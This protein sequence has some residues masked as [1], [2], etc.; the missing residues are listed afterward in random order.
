MAR[1]RAGYLAPSAVIFRTAMREGIFGHSRVW[2]VVGIA[3]LARRGL[4]KL[5]GAAPRTLAVERIRPGEMLI[6]RG[7][8][9]PKLPAS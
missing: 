2:K 8:R 9:S 4:K 6:L 5:M 1:R 3:I 7:V